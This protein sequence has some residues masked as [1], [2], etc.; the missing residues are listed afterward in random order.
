MV[1]SGMPSP[2]PSG[3]A[4][5]SPVSILVVEDSDD[6]LFLLKRAFLSANYHDDLIFVRDGEEALQ[7]LR[8]AL[9]GKGAK[10]PPSP[11]VLTVVYFV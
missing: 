10:R 7:F 3:S 1:I 9:A 11:F 6:D 5:A 2:F 8:D 4:S